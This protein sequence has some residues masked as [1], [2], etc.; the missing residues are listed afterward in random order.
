MFL[1][2]YAEGGFIYLLEYTET[3]VSVKDMVFY[4]SCNNV[5][6]IASKNLTK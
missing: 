3:R 5:Q 4:I 1:G 2:L 6:R